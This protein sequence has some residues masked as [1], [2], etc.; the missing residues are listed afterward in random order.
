MNK[1]LLISISIVFLA[2][3][4][5]FSVFK[6]IGV[7]KEKFDL[8][9]ALNLAKENNLALEKE[10]QNLLQE[11]EKAKLEQQKLIQ[12]QANL[13]DNLKITNNSL[14]KLLEHYAEEQAVLKELNSQFALLKAE[15]QGL[16]ERNTALEQDK[17]NLLKENQDLA[18]KLN[19]IP[20]LKKAIRDLKLQM[21]SVNKTGFNLA[22]R[23]QPQENEDKEVIE[24]NKGFIIKDG[25]LTYPGKVKIEVIPAS[26]KQ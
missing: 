21:R 4:T 8:S 15:N 24:G 5:A 23:Q 7:L 6:Y 19:S 18:A 11:L 12:E 9:A 22:M 3:I 1:G 25:Q 20:E 13:K 14:N 26:P 10:K 2:T 16:I 17:Q